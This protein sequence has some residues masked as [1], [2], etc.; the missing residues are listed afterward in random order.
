[1]TTSHFSRIVVIESLP[2]GQLHTGTRLH[3]DIAVQNVF[4]QRG[5]DVD[6]V[7]ADTAERLWACLARVLQDA[8]TKAVYPIL[9]IECH[10]STDTAGL[11]LA[12]NSFVSWHEIKPVLTAINIATRCNLFVA[13][14]ACH[15]AHLSQ[16]ILPTDRAPLW[17]MIGPVESAKP[18]D[19]F[20]SFFA[21]YSTLLASL[22]G[23]KALSAIVSADAR[24]AN[25]Y[26]VTAEGFFKKAYAHY[27][28]NY[29]TEK[30]RWRRAKQL[31]TRLR[32]M[33][34]R[35]SPSISELQQRLKSTELPSFHKYHRQFFMIDL[36]PENS[37]RFSVRFDEVFHQACDLTTAG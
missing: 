31:R 12:D 16:V 29:C 27:L 10:G 32:D 33:G 3:E 37:E 17:G 36:F 5:L 14:A 1:M 25:Y 6:R 11:V 9:H 19:L 30:S 13:L 34:L 4:H 26:F 28:A 35:K 21:F 20:G 18:T 2:K 22:D 23:D 7:Q 15:G 8:N 24:I